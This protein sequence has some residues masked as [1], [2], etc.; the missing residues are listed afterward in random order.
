MY[1]DRDTLERT[2][3]PKSAPTTAVGTES[4][5]CS[6]ENVV[7]SRHIVV[8]TVQRKCARTIAGV[9]ANVNWVNASVRKAGVAKL[10]RTSCARR[11]W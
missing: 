8:P 3:G 7:V 6:Q 10:V 2:V 1:A 9:M 4:V 5:I 11:L